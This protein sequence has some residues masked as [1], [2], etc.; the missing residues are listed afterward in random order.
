[1]DILETVEITEAYVAELNHF[2]TTWDNAY[3]NELEKIDLFKIDLTKYWSKQQKQLFTKIFYHIRGHF[4][5]FLWHMGNH[6]PSTQA[7]QMILQNIAEE[8]GIKGRS[9]EQLYF[10]FSACLGVDLNEEI[11]SEKHYLPFAR[12]F[13]KGHLEW[14]RTHSW[15]DNLIVFSAYERLDNIDYIGLYNLAKSF[16]LTKKELTFFSVHK[17]VE[18]FDSTL[19][20][21]YNIWLKDPI[22]IRN[23]FDFIARHQINMWKK[24]SDEIYNYGNNN[25]NYLRAD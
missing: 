12:D 11:S 25:H 10:D 22:K 20:Y 16:R 6:A 3:K 2:L 5:D 18:H 1:M 19:D 4:H 21:L 9:H 8:F 17:Y 24:L 23:G 14:L 15:E 13:N 7:K